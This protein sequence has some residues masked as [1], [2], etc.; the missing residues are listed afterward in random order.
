MTG[1]SKDVPHLHIGNLHDFVLITEAGFEHVLTE[2]GL[3]CHEAISLSCARDSMNQLV[4]R[5]LAEQITIRC[6]KADLAR[7]RAFRKY[8]REFGR[9]QFMRDLPAPAPAG[10]WYKRLDDYEV[11][12]VRH[13]ESNRGRNRSPLWS[14]FVPEALG[15]FHALFDERPT[16][17]AKPRN[18]AGSGYGAAARFLDA[19]MTAV[20]ESF[21]RLDLAARQ[22]ELKSVVS[23]WKPRSAQ[24]LEKMIQEGLRATRIVRPLPE[25]TPDPGAS[26]PPLVARA[27]PVWPY[28]ARLYRRHLSAAPT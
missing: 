11:E 21:D 6:T 24:T 23:H 14:M 15:I 26:P 3:P 20:S 7:L 13:V 27:D 2:T 12:L 5:T 10:E 1:D 8:M 25:D 16:A 19:C 28:Y 4:R 17:T 22:K 9:G 18:A